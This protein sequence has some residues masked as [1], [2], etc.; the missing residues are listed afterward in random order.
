MLFCNSSD[1]ESIENI[2]QK[3]RLC[4][5]SLGEQRN[6]GAYFEHPDKHFLS[7]FLGQ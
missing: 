4:Y 5:L 2:L 3:K 6:L 1:K 7:L